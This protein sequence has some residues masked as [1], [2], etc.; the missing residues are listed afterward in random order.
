MISTTPK[1]PYFAVIFTSLK[2]SDDAGYDKM[3]EKMVQL[4]KEQP[5]FLGMESVREEG[6]GITVSYW[7]SLDSISSWK[8]NTDHSAAQILGKE[9]WYD[10]YKV[11]ICRVE[12]DY[13][14]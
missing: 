7:Q 11:R 1:P 10:H 5:G 2:S 9:K 6:L 4:A 8:R 12:R 13:E 14:P 3:S